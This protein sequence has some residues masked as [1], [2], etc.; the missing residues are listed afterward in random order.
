MT[1]HREGRHMAPGG[2]LH[3][4]F[5]AYSHW[6][7]TFEGTITWWTPDDIHLRLR[8]IDWEIQLPRWPWRLFCRGRH[9]DYYGAC[10]FCHTPTSHKKHGV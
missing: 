3:K 7:I 9:E 5:S 6:A 8:K 1:P 4:F 10:I 2:R